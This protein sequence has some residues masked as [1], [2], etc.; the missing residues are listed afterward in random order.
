MASEEE[1]A[2]MNTQVPKPDIN[3]SPERWEKYWKVQGQPWRT[4]PE[5]DMNRQEE[6]PQRRAIVPNIE[7]G[8][9]PFKDMKLN[10]ADVEW[11][12]AT[13]ESGRGP[14]DCKDENQRERIGL[15]VR[16]ANLQEV[17]LS[18]LPLTRLRAGLNEN[19]W[20]KASARQ[21][22]V[23]SVS[24]QGANLSGTHLEEANLGRVHLEGSDLFKAHLDGADLRSAFFDATSTLRDAT[25]GDAHRFVSLADIRW[26]GVNLA[27]VKWQQEKRAKTLI[28]GDEHKARR[29]KISEVCLSR[30]TTTTICLPTARKA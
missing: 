8:I 1:E 16:G 15:D 28:L 25:F 7:K 22:R 21:I 14:V 18:N 29:H 2:C 10:R 30:T 23:A 17:E 5:I 13:H 24:F 11:L 6:L 4:E 27:V 26:G 3:D 19:E 9:Y 12:L 20:H